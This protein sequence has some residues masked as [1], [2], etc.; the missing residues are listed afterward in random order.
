MVHG[1]PAAIGKLLGKP[2]PQMKMSAMLPRTSW[3]P[4]ICCSLLDAQG[5]SALELAAKH[6]H[7][8]LVQLLLDDERTRVPANLLQAAIAGVSGHVGLMCRLRRSGARRWKLASS[9]L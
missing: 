7:W 5:R 3:N 6:A 8:Q 2:V 1:T 4:L 9:A